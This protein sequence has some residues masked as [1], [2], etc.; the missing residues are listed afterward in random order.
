MSEQ[1]KEITQ[2]II[3]NGSAAPQSAEE[4]TQPLRVASDAAQAPLP[5]WLMKFASSPEKAA[6]ESPL[7]EETDLLSAY[8]DDFA[9]GEA[10]TPP[11][12]PG[13][14]EWQELSDFQEQE[15]LETMPLE[16]PPEVSVETE[17]VEVPEVSSEANLGEVA[18]PIIP[19]DPQVVAAD[20]FKQEVRDL[21]NQGQ[22]KEALAKIRENKSDPLMAEAAKKTLRSQLTLSSETGDLWDIYDELNSSS[23]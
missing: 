7:S 21:L 17:N 2:P 1:E 5:D 23:I 10:F 6:D 3:V 11:P 22:R 18:E 9:D 15:A 12:I 16:A 19:V 4:G 14:Y 13:E 20:K 8:S